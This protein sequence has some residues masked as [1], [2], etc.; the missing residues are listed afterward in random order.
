MDTIKDPAAYRQILSFDG[1]EYQNGIRPT[2]IDGV[3]ET[4]NA[5]LFYEVKFSGSPVKRGQRLWM[6]RAVMD[7]SKG[8][9][10]ALAII[11]DHYTK[12]PETPVYLKDCIVREIYWCRM[13]HWLTDGKRT[14]GEKTRSYLKYVEAHS[15]RSGET[16]GS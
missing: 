5:Y 6:E 10:D 11:A 4:G 12:D 7:V 1:M 15:N 8:G 14:V 2:D 13:P 3:L 16:D 9:K